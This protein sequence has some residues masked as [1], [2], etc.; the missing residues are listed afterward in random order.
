MS[1]EFHCTVHKVLVHI[2]TIPTSREGGK[3]IRQRLC[4]RSNRI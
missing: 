2:H 3:A 1:K 4:N